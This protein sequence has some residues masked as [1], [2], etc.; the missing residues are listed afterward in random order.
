MTLFMMIT[1]ASIFVDIYFNKTVKTKNDIIYY[2]VCLLITIGLA[3]FY[4]TNPFRIGIAEYVLNILN[5]GGS[6]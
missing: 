5:V 3:I 2:A 4:Y 6:K 1:A